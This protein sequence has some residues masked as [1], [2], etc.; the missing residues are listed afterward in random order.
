M[1]KGADSI[2][3]DAT[4]QLVSSGTVAHGINIH[5]FNL[6]DSIINSEF[7]NNFDHKLI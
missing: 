6:I 7:I 4:Y 3:I 5:D 2:W 1:D